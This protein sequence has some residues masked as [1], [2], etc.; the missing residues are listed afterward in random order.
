[1]STEQYYTK[2]FSERDVQRLED[3]L[4]GY[5]HEIEKREDYK[6]E[7]GDTETWWR[8]YTREYTGTLAEENQ[9]DIGIEKNVVDIDVN[10]QGKDSKTKKI[11]E[12]LKAMKALISKYEAEN[13]I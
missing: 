12:L 1:V 3:I 11:T 9:K 4:Q 13:P 7:I 10:I 8:T 6:T 5:I 2:Y